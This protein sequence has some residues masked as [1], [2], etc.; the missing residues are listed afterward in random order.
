M[1]IDQFV[2]DKP[3]KVVEIAFVLQSL[4]LATHPGITEAWKWNTLCFM[5]GKKVIAY[6]SIKKG[7]FQIG[8]WRKEL[9]SSSIVKR[10]LKMIGY[11]LIEELSDELLAD[12]AISAEE[13]VAGQYAQK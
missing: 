11:Y 4:L 5:L 7:K 12:I 1:L 8:F 13:I 10:D 2:E 9:L 6:F 3:E